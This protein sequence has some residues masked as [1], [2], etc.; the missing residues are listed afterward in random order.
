[1]SCQNAEEVDKSRYGLRRDSGRVVD[2]DAK[3]G[4]YESVRAAKAVIT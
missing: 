3:L 1:M 2:V 4:R